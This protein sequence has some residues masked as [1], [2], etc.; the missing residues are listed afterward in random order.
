MENIHA[1]VQE[2]QEEER[3]LTEEELW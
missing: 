2:N 3:E 1:C